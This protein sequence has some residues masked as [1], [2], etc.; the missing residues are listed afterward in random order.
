M[1]AAPN[2]PL[3]ANGDPTA[4]NGNTLVDLAVTIYTI[5]MDQWFLTGDQA[6]LGGANPYALHNLESF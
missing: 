4:S 2:R 6:S 5:H 3:K 1:H